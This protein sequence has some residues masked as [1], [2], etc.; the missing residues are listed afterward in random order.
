MP[1]SDCIHVVIGIIKNTENQVL[2]TRRKENSHLGGL[3]EFPGGK[4][5]V[6]ET[7]IQALSRELKEELNINL[8]ESSELIQIP[9]EYPDRNVFLNV[10]YVNDYSGS[11]QA[12][13]SQELEWKDIS[14]LDGNLFPGAN[15]GIISALQIP[16]LIAVTPNFNQC[17]DE[18]LHNFEDTVKRDDIEI[19]H[20]RSHELSSDQ[21][22]Q[23]A[24]ECLKRC[25]ENNTR[26]VLNRNLK[27]VYELGAAGL[28]LT[29]KDLLSFVERPL[30]DEYFTSASCHNFEEVLHANKIKLDY[31][32]LG[33]LVEK[34]LSTKSSVLGWDKFAT[35]TKESQIPVY[36]IGGLTISD[37]EKANK[38]GGQG[39][40]AIRNLWARV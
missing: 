23:L 32:F 38:L 39:M 27:A 26:L 1:G 3:L 25:K 7:S 21:Y 4:I 31:I 22:I 5:N 40:A 24:K 37:I 36:G 35:L 18:F 28:H 19:I 16:K 2:I 13:E 30:G 9:F 11:I 6:N 14:V 10:Y 12:N 33:P 15:R 20:L 17:C 34:H 29:S 8:L